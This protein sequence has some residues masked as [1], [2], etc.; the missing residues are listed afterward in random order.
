MTFVFLCVFF[1]VVHTTECLYK[2]KDYLCVSFLS[3]YFV[4]PRDQTQILKLG[5]YHFHPLSYL[6]EPQSFLIQAFIGSHILFVWVKLK[7]I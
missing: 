3:F 6:A 1:F 5:G 7:D 2:F 4:G